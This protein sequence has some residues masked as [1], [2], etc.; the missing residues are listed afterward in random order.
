MQFI[1]GL[2][3]LFLYSYFQ[4]TNKIHRIPLSIKSKIKLILFGS[5]FGMTSIFYY[6]SIRYIPVSM[7]IILLMQS[8]WMSVVLEAILRKKTPDRFKIIGTL[9]IL[10]GTIF[11]TNVLFE[12]AIIDWRGIFLGLLAA[13]SYT[14]SMHASNHLATESSSYDRSKYF[15]LGGFLFI[16]A[17]WNMDIIIYFTS[18]NILF[19]GFLLALFGTIIPPLLFTQGMPLI[20][21]GLGAIIAAVEIPVSILSAHIVLDEHI[22][23]LQWLGVC[24]ILLAVVLVNFPSFKRQ[25]STKT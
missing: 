4:K 7:S 6:L 16:L 23:F 2:S 21:I 9:V 24:I 12:H 18:S 17:Y 8:I 3:T 22:T 14:I 13:C 1:V 11:A 19:W 20:G 15:V 25:K 10:V 5:T